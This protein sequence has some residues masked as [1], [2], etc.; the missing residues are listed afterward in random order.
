MP[1]TRER[2]MEAE[3]GHVARG[4]PPWGRLEQLMEV[5]PVPPSDAARSNDP[6]RAR[7]LDFGNGVGKQL[8]RR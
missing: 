7:L 5:R 8:G 6:T 1:I 4:I 3:E 2:F